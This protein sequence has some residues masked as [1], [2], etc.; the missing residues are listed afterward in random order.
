MSKNELTNKQ[1]IDMGIFT[2]DAFDKTYKCRYRKVEKLEQYYPSQ[3]DPKELNKLVAW[4]LNT[5]VLDDDELVIELTLSKIRKPITLLDY[6][7]SFNELPKLK[8]VVLTYKGQKG[9]SIPESRF[10]R[11]LEDE[12]IAES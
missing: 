8:D 7:K 10:L 5:G 2:V 9:W 3:V 11:Q 1:K 12:I 6:T 4:G